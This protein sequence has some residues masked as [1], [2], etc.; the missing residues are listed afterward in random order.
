MTIEHRQDAA[1]N[2]VLALFERDRGAEQ[3][4]RQ[5]L[6]SVAPAFEDTALQHA[7]AA[8]LADWPNDLAAMT[9]NRSLEVPIQR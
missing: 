7:L 6:S 1:V 9:A 8:P 2:V 3:S 4:A 5:L